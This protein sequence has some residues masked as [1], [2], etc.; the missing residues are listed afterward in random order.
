[1]TDLP[2]LLRDQRAIDAEHLRLLRIF[3]FVYGALALCGLLFLC[4]HYALMHTV[5]DNP[6][7]WTGKNQ[8]PPPPEFF[9]MFRWFYVFFGVF[10]VGAGL[11]NIASGV[12]LGRRT[13][14]TFSIVVAAL[15][16]LNM[17]L[18]TLLGVFAIV[19]LTRDSVR[20]VYG[21]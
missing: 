14:R 17:P 6:A 19:V 3:H 8:H 20:E 1:M 18:G 10:C 4:A 13:H 21:S 5:F 12:L 16:C 15:D 7:M 9:A 11:L 2:P